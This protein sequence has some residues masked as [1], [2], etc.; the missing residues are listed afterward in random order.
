MPTSLAGVRITRIG[1]LKK[2]RSGTLVTMLAP[3]GKKLLRAD[4]SRVSAH[5][6]SGTAKSRKKRPH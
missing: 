2:R 5:I 6:R 3:D 4:F 1:S